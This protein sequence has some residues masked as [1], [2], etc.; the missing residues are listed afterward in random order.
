M[1]N[2]WFKFYGGEYLS[3]PKITSLSACQRSCWVTLMSL[4]SMSSDGRV[5][6]LTENQLLMQS[7]VSPMHEEWEHTKGVLEVFVSLG[8]IAIGEEIVIKNWKKRQE[9]YLTGAERTERY[10][11]KKASQ[12]RH[13]SDE[14]VTQPSRKSDARR[15]EKRI[16][17]KRVKKIAAKAAPRP[18]KPPKKEFKA[19]ETRENWYAGKNSKNE[20]DVP[21][22]QLLAW[23]FDKKGLW[24]RLKSQEQVAAT[25]GR[26]I[27]AARA[28]IHGDWDS[29]D[30]EEA[31]KRC[32]AENP[33]MKTEWTIETL[34]KYLT[35]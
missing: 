15:E 6:Y 29:K 4:A 17:E 22:F 11:L 26:H 32:F 10:R 3:D 5:R 12:K 1:A 31:M 27:K 9:T 24:K 28:V 13:T 35:K 33:K 16:E 19:E 30:C 14:E 21:I 20:S 18:P 2:Q 8:M 7:G 34:L 23:Y 25:V